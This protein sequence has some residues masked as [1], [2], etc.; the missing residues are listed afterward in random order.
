MKKKEDVRIEIQ[1]MFGGIRG[2]KISVP[3]KD[4]TPKCGLD[5]DRFL[6]ATAQSY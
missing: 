3:R 1:R 5:F 2:L 4:E 6:A